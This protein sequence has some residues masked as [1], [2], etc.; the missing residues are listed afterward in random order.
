MSLRNTPTGKRVPCMCTF[1]ACKEKVYTDESGLVQSGNLIA[2]STRSK[3]K[4]KDR[5]TAGAD[6]SVCNIGINWHLGVCT[7]LM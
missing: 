6:V 7:Y 1:F 2:I 4:Q 5:E 3:H